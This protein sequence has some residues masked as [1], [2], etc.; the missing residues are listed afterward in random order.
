[1]NLNAPSIQFIWS[2]AIFPATLPKL[3]VQICLYPFFSGGFYLTRAWKRGARFLR[4]SIWFA[5]FRITLTLRGEYGPLPPKEPTGYT[6]TYEPPVP[7][8]EPA[9]SP[10]AS[11]EAKK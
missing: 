1:M 7:A 6:F 10:A 5:D 2:V 11:P 9:G 3:E 8:N 4:T